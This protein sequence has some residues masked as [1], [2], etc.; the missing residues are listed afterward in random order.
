MATDNEQKED[1]SGKGFAGLSSMVSDVDSAVTQVETTRPESS[2]ATASG[3]S[4]KPASQAQPARGPDPGPQPYQQTSNVPLGGS[5]SGK[6]L[7]G[8]GAVIG[9]IWLLSQ[10]GNK[11]STP[12]PAYSPSSSQPSVST[13]PAQTSQPPQAPPRPQAPSRP[14]EEQPPV[15]TNQVLGPSQIRY[16]LAED[17][18]LDA[19]KG[20]LNNYVESDVIRFNAMVADYNSRCGQFRYR[21]GSLESAKSE[22]ESIRALL[23]SE[24]RSRFI[25]SRGSNSRQTPSE[26]VPP[27]PD[28]TIL[29]VQQRLNALGYDVGAA[30]GF[31][32]PKTR[33][34]ISAYQAEQGLPQNGV[35]T[36]S[37]L[38]RLNATTLANPR[39]NRPQSETSSR[40]GD[41]ADRQTRQAVG[42][43]PSRDIANFRKCIDGRYPSLCNHTLLTS[44]EAVQVEAAERK[45][46]FE[47]C[48]DGRYPSLCNHS[49]LT[50][51]QTVRV[52]AAERKANFDKCIDGRYP[53]LCNHPLL[54]ADQ[55]NQV[56][57][58]ERRANL[59]KCIDGRYPSLCNHSLLTPEQAS[60]V[61]EAEFRAGR[62]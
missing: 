28:A 56:S 24:G 17:I 60:R 54:T 13:A 34:A 46:N 18:R 16:C 50:A 59:E 27:Q 35:A 21:R 57:A 48:I 38:G 44:T 26:T 32:G 31:A 11:S 58:A 39:T 1:K 23:Q 4:A 8:I 37:L 45:A 22:I 49:L 7:L 9:F 47:K 36:P 41:S 6:W 20:A 30:D 3:A 42:T 25:R 14:S 2:Q 51:D 40:L 29:S 15:A 53:S 55:A 5:S 19:A 33:S 10:S 43:E 62:R 12:A 61:N 52:E